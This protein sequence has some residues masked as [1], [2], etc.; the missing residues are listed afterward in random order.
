MIDENIERTTRARL[1]SWI[2][3]A[4]GLH[5]FKAT[6]PNRFPSEVEEKEFYRA[7]TRKEIASEEAWMHYAAFCQE[8]ASTFS[9]RK[10]EY[11]G[12][13]AEGWGEGLTWASVKIE[14]LKKDLSEQAKWLREYWTIGKEIKNER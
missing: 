3:V 1:D 6:R 9:S 14:R 5:N 12:D 7:I 10:Q 4:D 13:T 2:S 11:Q 8:I